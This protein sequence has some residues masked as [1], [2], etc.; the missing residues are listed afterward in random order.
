MRKNINV[1]NIRRRKGNVKVYLNIN[2]SLSPANIKGKKLHFERTSFMKNLSKYIGQTVSVFTTSGGSSGQGFTGLLLSVNS[3]F[4]KVITQIGPAPGSLL[5]FYYT[6]SL[7]N[8]MQNQLD[9]NSLGSVA[10]I[11]IRSIAAFVHNAVGGR[12]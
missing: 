12:D 5:G 8:N 11:P 7:G 10:D 1:F 9:I 4:I 2:N 6:A 3:D